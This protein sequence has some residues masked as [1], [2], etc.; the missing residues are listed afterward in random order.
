MHEQIPLVTMLSQDTDYVDW[1]SV[2]GRMPLD[3]FVVSLLQYRPVWLQSMYAFRAI[4]AGI[5]G[6]RLPTMT[7]TFSRSHA[8]MTPGEQ[9]GPFRVVEAAYDSYWIGKTE[10]KNLIAHIVVV[11]SQQQTDTRFDV[12]TFVTFLRPTGRL[13]FQIVRPFHHLVL[14]T[15]MAA[16][17]RVGR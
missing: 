13:Y 5:L 2:C 14:T 1:K 15:A 6:I 16:A 7:G 11:A 10:D 17:V 12:G 3:R 4:V 8:P 9:L